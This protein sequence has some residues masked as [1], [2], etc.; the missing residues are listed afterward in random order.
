MSL[1]N[2]PVKSTVDIETVK[3]DAETLEKIRSY[4]AVLGNYVSDFG[5][6]YLRR[7]DLA[8]ELVRLDGMVES[9]EKEFKEKSKQLN[10][11]LGELDDKYPQGRVNMQDGTVTY[12]PGAPSRKQLQQ[13]NS[14][15]NAMKVVKE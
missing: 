9:L 15:D 6:I 14:Q 10:D 2:I 4:N 3:I 5:N 7:K 12:Q 13:Q 8:D 11:L 1:D